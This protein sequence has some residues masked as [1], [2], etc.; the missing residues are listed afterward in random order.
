MFNKKTMIIV[1]ILVISALLFSGLATLTFAQVPQTQTCEACGMMVAADSQAHIKVVDSTGMPHYVDCLKCALKLLKNYGEL[2]IVATCDW[3][4]PNNVININLKNFVNTTIVTPSSAL[5]IDG[6]CTKNRVVYDQAAAEALLANNGISQY[7]TLMQNVTI[8]PSA[9]VL[10]IPQAAIMYAFTSSP[11]PTPTPTATPN[12]TI[13][14][15][16]ICEA[17]GMNVAADAQAKY[18][19]IDGNGVTHY[20]ECYMCALNLI[21]HY[22]KL[23]ITS[24]CDWYGPNYTVTVQSQNFGQEV[25]VTPS[26]ALF[27]NGGSC[28]IN[29]VAYNQTAADALL[30]FG[31]SMNTL[32]EQHYDLPKETN[33][34]TVSKAALA[35][36]TNTTNQTPTIP[37]VIGALAGIAII[38]LS[39]VAYK[40]LK[41]K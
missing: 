31:F 9:T 14:V 4:G 37:L 19:I 24:Y 8:P 20:A 36:T 41:F 17:C 5:Y 21:K 2:N 23:T 29:R 7:S 15:N 11:D 10:T 33:V 27:L 3:N 25:T 16:Q 12:S 39:V 32:P 30:A 26:T 18:T 35:L 38:S 28:V 34:T 40:K 6:G 1:D 22:D 13:V